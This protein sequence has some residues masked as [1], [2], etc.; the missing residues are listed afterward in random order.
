MRS[1]ILSVSLILFGTAL[2]LAAEEK[3][4]D[5]PKPAAAAKAPALPK[6]D[7]EKEKA[8]GFVPLFDG[9]TLSGWTPRGG[10]GE[11]IDEVDA[12][13]VVQDGAI[14][15]PDRGMD[16]YLATKKEYGDFVLRLEYKLSSAS[17]SGVFLRAPYEDPG[18]K[19]FEVQVIDDVGQEPTSHTSG[20][21]FDV[22]TPMRNMSRPLGEWNQLEVRLKGLDVIVILNGFKVIDADFAQLTKPLGKF[23]FAYAKMPAVG[24]IGLQSGGGE[25]W[26]RNIRI[27]TLNAEK[28]P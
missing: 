19:G 25:F 22:L 21:I 1:F 23:E 18:M 24:H 26:Y 2:V 3:T 8:D 13:F 28:K 5:Q 4:G 12:T 10:S 20:A 17:N 14:Y 15:C 6:Y 16:D 9:K 27:K 7:P 11:E